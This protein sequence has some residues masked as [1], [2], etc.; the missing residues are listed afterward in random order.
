MVP[1]LSEIRL[2]R[3]NDA[4]EY[5]E[6]HGFSV[7][8]AVLVD[9]EYEAIIP[10][11]PIMFGAVTVEMTPEIYARFRPDYRPPPYPVSTC[12]LLVG[13]NQLSKPPEDEAE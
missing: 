3:I 12:R 10:E 7:G 2:Q 8:E 6:Q 11:A 9:G 4:R 5:I 13:I 1:T